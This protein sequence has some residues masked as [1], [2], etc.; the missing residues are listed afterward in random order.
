MKIEDRQATLWANYFVWYFFCAAAFSFF[1]CVVMYV[2]FPFVFVFVLFSFC[3]CNFFFLFTI[4]LSFR[5][6]HIKIT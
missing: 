5:N 2:Y 6:L 3:C 4:P 1:P